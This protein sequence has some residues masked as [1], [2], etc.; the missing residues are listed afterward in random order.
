M[1]DASIINCK[2]VKL[3]PPLNFPTTH[4]SDHAYTYHVAT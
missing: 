4:S 2:F 1:V 3:N